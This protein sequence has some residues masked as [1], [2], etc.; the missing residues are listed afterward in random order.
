MEE[1][2]ELKEVLSTVSESVEKKFGPRPYL[3]IVTKADLFFE[4]DEAKKKGRVTGTANYVYL[5]KPPIGKDSITKL[6]IDTTR[7]ALN[8]MEK[9]AT[10]ES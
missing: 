10:E 1:D 2:K 3:I 9:K 7:V 6:L 8:S 4:D 5:T